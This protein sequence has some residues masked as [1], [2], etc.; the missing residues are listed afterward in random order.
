MANGEQK[1]MGGGVNPFEEQEKQQKRIRESLDLID[2]K[3]MVMS[4][5]G[6]VGKSTVSV[7]LALELAILGL[8]LIQVSVVLRGRHRGSLRGSRWCCWSLIR[9]YWSSRDPIGGGRGLLGR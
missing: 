5:K 1:G 4:G 3:I 7:N 9:G 2:H 6:G 8:E